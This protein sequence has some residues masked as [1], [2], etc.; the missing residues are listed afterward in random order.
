MEFTNAN[1]TPAG[2]A[3]HDAGLQDG[4]TLNLM[5]AQSQVVVLNLLGQHNASCEVRDNIAAHG[6]QEVQVW[7]KPINARWLDGV[8]LRV[9]VAI[10]G[11]ESTEDQRQQSAQQLGHLCT[12]LQELIDGAPAPAQPAEATA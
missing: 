3:L 1:R 4:F 7:T 5:R 9:S 6:G 2:Q 12:A 11:P 8:G 10:P